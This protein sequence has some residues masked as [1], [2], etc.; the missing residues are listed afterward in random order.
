VIKAENNL[1]IK[2]KFKKSNLILLPELR[3]YVLELFLISLFLQLL[4]E[5]KVFY[6]HQLEHVFVQPKKIKLKL[7]IKKIGFI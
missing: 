6:P 5:D 2:T 1:Y 3:R 7:K 4:L